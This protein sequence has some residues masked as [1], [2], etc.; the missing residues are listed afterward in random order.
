M[1]ATANVWVRRR[2]RG[3]AAEAGFSMVLLIMTITVLGIMLGAALPR[4]S[5]V[6][7]RDKEE[8]LIAR[9]WQYV[10]A[11][12]VFQKRF[13]RFPTTLDEMIKVKPRCI[14]QL[15]KDPMTPD[16]QFVPIFQGQ[17]SQ[18]TPIPGLGQPGLGTTP[19]QPPPGTGLN[20]GQP[21]PPPGNGLDPNNPQIAAGPIIG[22]HSRSTQKSLLVFYGHE[23]YNEWEF[24]IE[25]LT[26]P[27]PSL[28]QAGIP[29][30]GLALS[31]RWLGRP[32]ENFAPTGSGLQPSALTPPGGLGSPAPTAPPP[33]APPQPPAP[34]G[35]GGPLE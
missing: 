20:P 21:N 23:H 12:R 34:L 11:I 24:R 1:V 30:A 4:W 25:L 7:Q 5:E 3:V 17:G 2:R 18:L 27:P 19:G 8:E 32:M 35:G 15:W 6:I 22:V 13:Q 31:T 26:R 28:A 29:S 16:G 33:P 10:E 9:G 14:R